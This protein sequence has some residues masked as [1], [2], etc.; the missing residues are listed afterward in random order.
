MKNQDEE[1]VKNV[2]SLFEEQ[3]GKILKNISGNS[4]SIQYRREIWNLIYKGLKNNHPL[5]VSRKERAFDII[6]K[7]G[8]DVG[9]IKTCK[10]VKEYNYYCFDEE[11]N[12]TLTVE[13][14]NFVMEMLENDNQQ[15]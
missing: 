14:Y 10:D 13:E 11:A 4:I 12:K 15:E 1:E 5:A 3:L 8:V 7:K 6:I 2:I 9:F